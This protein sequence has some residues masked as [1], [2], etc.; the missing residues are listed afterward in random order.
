MVHSKLFL[1]RRIIVGLLLLSNNWATAQKN[2]TPNI[3]VIL[4][5]D[6]GYG[7]VK[8]FYPKSKIPTPQIDRLASEGMRF[9]DAHSGSAYCSP[10]RYGILTGRY[11]WRTSLRKGVLQPYDPPIIARDRLTL[12]ELLRQQGYSTACI[13]KWHLGW[14]WPMK[15]GQPDFSRPISDG[16][17]TRGFDY[18][19][20]TDVPNYPP[21]CFIENDRTVG[22]PSDSQLVKKM[23][24]SYVLRYKGPAVPDWEP[25]EI[26][27]KIGQRAVRY[28]KDHAKDK[29]PFFL[30]FTLTSPHEPIAPSKEWQGRSGI[31]PVADFIMETDSVV[32][33]VV[34]AVRKNKLNKNTL[35]IFTSDNGHAPYTGLKPLLDAGHNPSG[36][37][38]G[39]KG[40][41]WEGGHHI[42]FIAIWPGKIKPGTVNSNV[43]CLTDLMATC[44]EVVG[45]RMPANAGEDSYSILPGF[46]SSTSGPTRESIIHQGGDGSLSIRKGPWKL[47]V[48]IKSGSAR[49]LYNL[50][51]DTSEEKDVAVENPDIVRQLYTLMEK[52]VSEGRS[53]PGPR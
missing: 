40:D 36:P 52:C 8:A 22:I 39:Y 32:G 9:T 50:S 6:L 20:G 5:D 19:F 23:P 28:I 30:Y 4:T 13:G 2:N 44:A 43:I 27:P 15:D 1:F 26:L 31:N 34:A 17:T 14:N 16:P 7:D 33:A 10:T 41:S 42:P 48:P 25:T 49:Q 18:Y 24:A 38:R 3:I 51:L 37:F 35:I 46:L 47:I 45:I 11:A 29:K 12:P 21:Y 53:T